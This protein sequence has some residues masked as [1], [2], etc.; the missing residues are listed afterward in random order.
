[1][2][3][4]AM[5]MIVTNAIK[6]ALQAAAKTAGTCQTPDEL[7]TIKEVAKVL[8]VS[9]NYANMLV[10]SGIIPGLRMH[11]MKVR[12]RALEEWMAAMEGQ[13]LLDPANPVPLKR[14]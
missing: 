12:R 11:G 4:W 10:Q 9:V 14:A 2:E 3:S 1:M 7:L 6:N 5:E 8:K 13:D